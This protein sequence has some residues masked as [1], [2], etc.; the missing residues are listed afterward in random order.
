[1]NSAHLLSLRTQVRSLMSWKEAEKRRRG[2]QEEEE[3]AEARAKAER[4]VQ[5]DRVA[6]PVRLVSGAAREDS[7]DSRSHAIM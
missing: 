5:K 7:L 3:K 2:R 6:E 4:R 1:M